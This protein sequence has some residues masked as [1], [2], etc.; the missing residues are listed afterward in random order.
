MKK[1]LIAAAISNP[2]VRG[3][4][5]IA[6]GIYFRNQL[7]VIGVNRYKTHPIMLGGEYRKE[8]IYLHAEADAI[9]KATR[10]CLPL[11]QCSLLVVRVKRCK[12]NWVEA[13][14]KPCKGCMNLI[15]KFELKE[16]SWTQ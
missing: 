1:K 9:V 12:G 3:R 8:Q 6:A 5:K 10:L 16:V 2:G 11:D 15:S 7:K 13:L 14:A 4:Y